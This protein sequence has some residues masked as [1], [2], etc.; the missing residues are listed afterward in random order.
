MGCNRQTESE[1]S[2]RDCFKRNRP[3]APAKQGGV[4]TSCRPPTAPEFLTVS[5][6]LSYHIPADPLHLPAAC[7]PFFHPAPP[8]VWREQRRPRKCYQVPTP[9]TGLASRKRDPSPSSSACHEGVPASMEVLQERKLVRPV[10]RVHFL[11]FFLPCVRSSWFISLSPRF[12]FDL[13]LE[14]L[15]TLSVSPWVP[16]PSLSQISRMAPTP[17]CRTASFRMGRTVL[18]MQPKSRPNTW[19]RSLINGR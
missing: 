17:M 14:I 2:K 11:S 3:V 8:N 13:H 1:G 9:E 10:V 15:G 12:L 6:L 7:E 16:K 5:L 18:S 4:P 19:A